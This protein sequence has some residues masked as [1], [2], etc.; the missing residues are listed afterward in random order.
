MRRFLDRLY[1]LCGVLAAVFIVCIAL[2]I[3]A[4]VTG[5]ML[6]ILIPA[7]TEF[8]GYC[9]ASAVFLALAHTLVSGEHIRVS[10]LLQRAPKRIRHWLEIWCLV[11]GTG[12]SL[13]FAWHIVAFTYETF[14]FEEVGHGLIKTPLWI[15]QSGMAL[16]M[17]VLAIAF[18]DEL[19]AILTGR[20]PRHI[21]ADADEATHA[22]KTG[23]DA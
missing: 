1:Q 19:F 13:Y 21:A 9:L 15:P 10:M 2:A 23:G 17:V 7:A 6:G 3:L 12:I 5:R 22:V 20:T 11:A 4:E 8:A 16:G 14:V 18:L